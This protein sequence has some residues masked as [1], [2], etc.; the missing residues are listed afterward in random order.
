MINLLFA[1][2]LSGVSK[3]TAAEPKAHGIENVNLHPPSQ[4]VNFDNIYICAIQT[5]L[6]ETPALTHIACDKA[7][8]DTPAKG[9][10]SVV[11]VNTARCILYKNRT[12]TQ[13]KLA[14]G[15]SEE[16]WRRNGRNPRD[17]ISCN[18]N[19]SNAESKV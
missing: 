3:A 9:Y 4:A 8:T 14:G 10:A 13:R 12:Y 16:D 19:K 6:P 5:N 11:E 18:E 17:G 2:A 15:L 1:V 7:I